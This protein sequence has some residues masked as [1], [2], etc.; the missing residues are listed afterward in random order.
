MGWRKNFCYWLIV[1]GAACNSEP[2]SIFGESYDPATTTY[3]RA[4]PASTT[5]DT[6]R[7]CPSASQAPLRQGVHR[8]DPDRVRPAHGADA[9]ASSPR[10]PDARRAARPP[11]GVAGTSRTTRSPARSRALSATS[12]LATS[13]EAT[14]S[15]RR[16]ARRTAAISRMAQRAIPRPR[17][18]RPTSPRPS[19]RPRRPTSPRPGPRPRPRPRPRF[20]RTIGGSST[21][22]TERFRPGPI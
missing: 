6:A 18:R 5:P 21:S 16:A 20:W 7:D 9:P 15:S 11:L 22:R 10:V 3:L 13:K 2:V 4:P 17:P 1:T 19:P 12:G 8:P 14:T